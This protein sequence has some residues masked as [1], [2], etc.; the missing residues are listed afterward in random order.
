MNLS[1]APCWRPNSSSHSGR[2]HAMIPKTPLQVALA[3]A[4]LL[5]LLAVAFLVA[6]SGDF[7]KSFAEEPLPAAQDRIELGKNAEAGVALAG[8]DVS[9]CPAADD[10][11]ALSERGDVSLI[12]VGS[13]SHA[14][15]SDF[16]WNASILEGAQTPVRVL[17]LWLLGKASRAPPY[18]I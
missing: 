8:V 2:D 10:A 14:W 9:P 12:A 5:L 11:P 1:G 3:T 15:G 13:R 7:P 18:R 16:F 4:R 17:R 6:D